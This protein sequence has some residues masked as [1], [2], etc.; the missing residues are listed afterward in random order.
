MCTHSHTHSS[1]KYA[2]RYF[3]RNRKLNAIVCRVAHIIQN[4]RIFMQLLHFHYDTTECKQMARVEHNKRFLESRSLSVE[5][6]TRL[7]CDERVEFTMTPLKARL[8]LRLKM[9]R[10]E[11]RWIDDDSWNQLLSAQWGRNHVVKCTLTSALPP[12]IES[13]CR[14]IV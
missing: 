13:S 8:R 2:L 14:R 6:E 9:I 10:D 7:S 11:R 3:S 12:H 5:G 1:A 4:N